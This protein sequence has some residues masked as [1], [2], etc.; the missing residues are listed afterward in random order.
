VSS[1]TLPVAVDGPIVQIR[2]G[3]ARS[4]ELAIRRAGRPVRPPMDLAGLV[5]TG[6]DVSIIEHGL[7]THFVRDQM[8]LLA[9]VHVNA[10]GLGGLAIRPQFLTGLRVCHPSRNPRHDLVVANTELV[11]HSF[12]SS[13]FQVLIGRDILS[14][15]ELHY[16]GPANQFTLTY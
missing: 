14:Q 11:E 9:F 6:A 8:P 4:T 3:F 10:P 2:V 5:D 13:G 15:I 16:D 1:I 7:L 12:G